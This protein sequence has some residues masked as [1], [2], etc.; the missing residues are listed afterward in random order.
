MKFIYVETLQSAPVGMQR[1]YNLSF[2]ILSKDGVLY[3]MLAHVVSKKI[4]TLF[5]A[6]IVNVNIHFFQTVI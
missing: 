2:P 6:R 5:S 1:L 4:F 3:P